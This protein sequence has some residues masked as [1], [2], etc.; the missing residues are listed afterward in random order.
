MVPPSHPIFGHASFA[1]PDSAMDQDPSHS[2]GNAR[3]SDAM[4]W[5]PTDP[6]AQGNHAQHSNTEEEQG[7]WLRPQRFFAPEQ[8]TGLETL[9]A[10]TRL[11][12]SPGQNN[13]P[14]SILRRTLSDKRRVAGALSLLLSIVA[15]FLAGRWLRRS[16]GSTSSTGPYST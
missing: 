3:E 8:P 9:F 1:P 7:S 10:S 14:R 16:D 12:D 6:R 13:A 4:D 11:D 15:A 2:P 5:Q